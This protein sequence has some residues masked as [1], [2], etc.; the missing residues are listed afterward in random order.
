MAQC[1][2]ST[3]HNSWSTWVQ[4]L[5]LTDKWR[6][7]LWKKKKESSDLHAAVT[8]SAHVLPRPSPYIHPIHATHTVIII[9]NKINFKPLNLVFYF[10]C[11]A[12][13]LDSLTKFLQVE[14]L[15]S[16]HSGSCSQALNLSPTPS[17]A[18]VTSHREAVDQRGWAGC[19]FFCK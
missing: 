4:P 16:N 2:K 18:F 7:W 14:H 12:L 19:D 1:I 10:L 17:T 8:V 5:N 15:W 6:N 3:F 11:L 9:I 13:V